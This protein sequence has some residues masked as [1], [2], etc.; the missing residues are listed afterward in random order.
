MPKSTKFQ[1][2]ILVFCV[3]L[4]AL[5]SAVII[6]DRVPYYL[7]CAYTKDQ[8]PLSQPIEGPFS[9]E[10]DLVDL[11]SNQ[12]KVLYQDGGCSITVQQVLHDHDRFS[13]HFICLPS[14]SFSGVR[15]VVPY[16]ESV[17]EVPIITN[18]GEVYE[19]RG[20]GGGAGP[21]GYKGWYYGFGLPL[22]DPDLNTVQN[23]DTFHDI[24]PD[25]ITITFPAINEYIWQS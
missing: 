7:Y 8:E 9:L 16:G 14:I 21:F 18:R 1:N 22:H 20:A 3:L 10:L 17:Q 11:D 24:P 19:C 25:T 12:G 4:L 2:L 13:V 15:Q 5:L 6:Q 23:Q